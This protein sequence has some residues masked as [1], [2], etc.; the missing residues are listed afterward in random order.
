MDLQENN[1]NIIVYNILDEY[2]KNKNDYKY[3]E[4]L[5]LTDNN[6]YIS[7]FNLLDNNDEDINNRLIT[8]NVNYIENINDNDNIINNNDEDE[9]EDAWE[10]AINDDKFYINNK[11]ARIFPVLKKFS[12]F[13][14][15]KI[16]ED[17]FSYITIREIAEIISK[18][19][20]YH[21][22]EHNLNPLKS[23]IVDYTSGV[24]GNALSFCKFFK[25]VYAIELDKLRA[26]YL[27]NNIE[28]YGFK[29]IN[30]I[31]K[32]AIEF[33]NEEMLNLNPNIIFVDPPWG[34]SAYKNNENL[35]LNLGSMQLE[36]LVIDITKKFSEHYINIVNLNSKQ[37]NNN[38]NNKFIVL[39]LPKNYDVEYFYNHIKSNNNFENY[40]IHLYLYILNKMIII[41]CELQY[42]F[43]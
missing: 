28:I 27:E 8:E 10:T 31:N 6:H 15:I 9:D 41:V 13:S 24:G 36:E 19:I 30:V 3:F 35:T 23:I 26:E 21:L 38:Y 14:K 22:L 25:L 4:N 20:C 7:I 2:I 18:I 17:S 32:C 34:G 40:Y 37:K 39:K 5:Y 1:P 11:I 12:N 16:D 43:Y 33:N 42:K 29:N